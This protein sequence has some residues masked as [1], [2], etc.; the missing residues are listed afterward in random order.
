M[1]IHADTTGPVP[2]N[3]TKVD[4]FVASVASLPYLNPL[5]VPPVVLDNGWGG[6]LRVLNGRVYGIRSLHRSE[7]VVMRFT[8]TVDLRSKLEMGPLHGTLAVVLSPARAVGPPFGT[9]SMYHNKRELSFDVRT[10]NINFSAGTDFESGKGHLYALTLKRIVNLNA[11]ID[12]M[13]MYGAVVNLFTSV[14]WHHAD[15][16]VRYLVEDVLRS[17]MADTIKY[18][19][20]SAES[21]LKN[22]VHA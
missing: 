9:S 20:L 6:L 15:R 17:V 13:D 2:A 11:S 18:A 7:A 16:F 14:L 22:F 4:E 5:F 12:E 10:V 19:D 8:S 21:L 3:R 1:A